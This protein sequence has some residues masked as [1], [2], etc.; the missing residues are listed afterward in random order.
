VTV[1][2]AVVGAAALHGNEV[3]G[4]NQKR[5]GPAQA[6][7]NK[8]ARVVV[9]C[10]ET[11]KGV[12]VAAVWRELGTPPAHA[13][14]SARRARALVKH[15]SLKAW[16][17]TLARCPFA[18]RQSLRCGGGTKRT[19]RFCP[20]VEQLG[21]GKPGGDRPVRAEQ[22]CTEVLGAV[23][24]SV[25]GGITGAA[26]APCTGRGRVETTWASTQTTPST[27]GAEQVQSERGLRCST[28]V[29]PAAYGLLTGWR[30]STLSGWS[31]TKTGVP[32]ARRKRGRR[33]AKHVLLKCSKWNQQR[34]ECTGETTK[35]AWNLS[36]PVL[37]R[38]G[39]VAVL[40]G[41]K[42]KQCKC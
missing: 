27:A 1:F 24:Q 32:A 42:E 29:G 20:S 36:R 17:G 2:Q 14:A 40:G 39:G 10:K 23:W 5:C 3:R 38:P 28:C 19:K 13:E 21:V 18:V 11:D 37:S 22:A 7:M 26:S 31:S 6:L 4:V 8:A 30:G 9:Q 33:R 34:Q 25:E 12:R 35:A 15:P 16:T 41:F